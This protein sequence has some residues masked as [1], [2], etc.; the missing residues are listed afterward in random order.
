MTS[1]I[2][3]SQPA[4]AVSKSLGDDSRPHVVIIGGGFGGLTAAQTLKHAPVRVTLVD[5]S[6][7]HVFQPLLYQ[8]ATAGLSP[9][10]IASP[11]RS[12]LHKQKN[13][14]VLLARVTGI[15]LD[16]RTMSLAEQELGD[17]HY[18][19]LILA[20]GAQNSYF[21]NDNWAQFTLG[22]KDLDDAIEIRRRVL[23]AFE[24]AERNPDAGRREQLLT[25][26]VIGGGPTGVEMAGAL[27]ELSRFALARDFRAINPRSTRIILVEMAGRILS[28]FPEDLSAKAARQLEELGVQ[29]R[30]GIRVTAIDARGV[31]VGNELI[32]AAIVIWAAGVRAT[33]TTT[34]LGVPID[35]AG[36]IIVEP[37]CSIPGHSNAFAI[38]DTTAYL[39]EGGK[40]LPG[41]SPVAMQQ[42]RFVARNIERAV[43][44]RPPKPRFHY[45]NKGNMATI[46]R[47]RA[48]ADLGRIKLSGLPAWVAWLVVHLFFLIG[49]RNRLLVMIDWAYSYFTYKRGVR[50]ITGDSRQ[51]CPEGSLSRESRQD[52]AERNQL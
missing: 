19:Y 11:I 22:L 50:L 14:R 3:S 9:S 46:G 40:P 20:T 23:L 28:S 13:T 30:T 47:S 21:G 32:P 7:H 4:L 17:M 10:E 37:N 36:R 18:D 34:G 16:T 15:D 29:V 51:G 31:Q 5:K 6:N 45:F 12:V 38:G 25:F 44:G 49:F 52:S 2:S 41:V 1:D 33:P 42:G 26:V 24:E 48:I 43:R 27:S 39:H 35:R 8:V